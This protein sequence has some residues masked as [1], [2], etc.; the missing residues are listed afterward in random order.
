MQQ[1]PTDPIDHLIDLPNIHPSVQPDVVHPEEHYTVHPNGSTGDQS[2]DPTLVS[3]QETSQ[4]DENTIHLN[5]NIMVAFF[6]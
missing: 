6:I 5:D 4:S 1:N 3:P 2:H